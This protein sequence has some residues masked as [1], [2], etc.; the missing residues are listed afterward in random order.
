MNWSPSVTGSAESVLLTARS[1]AFCENKPCTL[2]APV[3]VTTQVPVPV[4]SP[5]QPRNDAPESGIADSVTTVG[6]SYVSAQSPP[7]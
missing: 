6:A 4:Q 1:V 3:I 5:L 2:R 7:Q